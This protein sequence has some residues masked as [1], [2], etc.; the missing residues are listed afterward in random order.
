MKLGPFLTDHRPLSVKH[1][2]DPRPLQCLKQ[3]TGIAAIAGDHYL[4]HLGYCH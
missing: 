1:L 2:H 4:C 3:F